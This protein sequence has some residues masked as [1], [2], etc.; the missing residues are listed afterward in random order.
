MVQ[1][2]LLCYYVE[3]Y[4]DVFD[5]LATPSAAGN[6]GVVSH[7]ITF[8]SACS[9]VNAHVTIGY[10]LVTASGT[11]LSRPGVHLKYIHT[12]E[13]LITLYQS[14]KIVQMLYLSYICFV[15]ES[16]EMLA[17]IVYLPAYVFFQ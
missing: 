2:L 8:T 3:F 15:Q 12:L 13:I 11:L 4:K 16:Q 7:E 9:H 17:D 5:L 1:E 6:V 10:S 14:K